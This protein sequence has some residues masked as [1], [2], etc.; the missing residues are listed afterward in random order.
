MQIFH[1]PPSSDYQP[2]SRSLSLLLRICQKRF[3]VP[4]DV[5]VFHEQKEFKYSCICDIP[6]YEILFCIL[7]L[8]LLAVLPLEDESIFD[9]SLGELPEI[10]FITLKHSL[11]LSAVFFA[12]KNIRMFFFFLQFEHV[13]YNLLG[14]RKYVNC[15]T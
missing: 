3:L 7:G 9:F 4:F 12:F 15:T 14:N 5:L 2:P 11:F 1:L 13:L 10:L 8:G 6:W